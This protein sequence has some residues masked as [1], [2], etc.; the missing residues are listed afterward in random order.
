[1]GEGRT[2][3]AWGR[4]RGRQI[5]SMKTGRQGADHENRQGRGQRRRERGCVRRTERELGWQEVLFIHSTP[6]SR[7]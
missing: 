3:R 4:D 1:M 5:G 7:S 6:G 2:V